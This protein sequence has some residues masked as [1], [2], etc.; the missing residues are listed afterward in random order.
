M[1]AYLA[2]YPTGIDIAK[3]TAGIASPDVKGTFE[4]LVMPRKLPAAN[5]V[6]DAKPA[7]DNAMRVARPQLQKLYAETFARNKL[8]ALIFPTVPRV[9]LAATPEA[10]SPENFSALIQNTDPGSNAGIPG[11]QLP[12]G[13]GATTG[14]PVGLEL[15]GPAGSDRKLLAIG[16]AVERELGRLPPP[17]AK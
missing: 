7:Y 16:L 3:L 12:A 4:G 13:L 14:L 17:K 5:G 6:V 10:S 1:V 11:I 2:R 9:A 8:D 15:D